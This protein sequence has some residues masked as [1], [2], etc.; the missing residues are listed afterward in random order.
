MSV[1]EFWA[2]VGCVFTTVFLKYL[3]CKLLPIN[4]ISKA[5]S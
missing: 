5:Y 4:C 1:G 3:M 2:R